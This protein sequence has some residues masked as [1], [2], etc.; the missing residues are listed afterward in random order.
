M[1]ALGVMKRQ[2]LL[3]RLVFQ[4]ESQLLLP[5]LLHSED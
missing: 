2:M 5:G 1:L 3:P 4:E